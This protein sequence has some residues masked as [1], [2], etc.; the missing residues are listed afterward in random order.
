MAERLKVHE[1]PDL[2][3]VLDRSAVVDVGRDPIAP[4]VLAQRLVKE[5]PAPRVA[6]LRRVVDLAVHPL[7]IATVALSAMRRTSAAGDRSL[8]TAG[9][10][11]QP[12]PARPRDLE[13]GHRCRLATHL[14]LP[15]TLSIAAPT[16]FV[17][18]SGP[19]GSRSRRCG[20]SPV[21][22]FVKDDPFLEPPGSNGHIRSRGERRTGGRKPD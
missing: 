17:I 11:A 8:D 12:Q 14:P 1:R 5:L 6:P 10:D 2:A 4:L 7:P 18:R 9:L 19:R 21:G 15:P 3:A 16:S 22:E 20:D 13:R